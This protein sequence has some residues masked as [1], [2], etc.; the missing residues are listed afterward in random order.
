MDFTFVE[1]I[2]HGHILAAEHLK[3]D[4]PLCG[5]VC[6]CL[7]VCLFVC[8]LVCIYA[9][10]SIIQGTC[11]RKLENT[12]SDMYTRNTVLNLVYTEFPMLYL[13]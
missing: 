12:L 9:N 3:P 8:W 13:H 1:N 4:S 7:F 11:E 2:V 10:V 5:K 6:L